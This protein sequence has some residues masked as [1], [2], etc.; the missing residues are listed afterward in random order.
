MERFCIFVTTGFM[1]LLS[2]G[3]Q[4]K[5]RRKSSKISMSELIKRVRTTLRL[6]KSKSYLKKLDFRQFSANTF[7]E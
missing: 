6:K 4:K 7:T 3:S 5:E 2:Y 1:I